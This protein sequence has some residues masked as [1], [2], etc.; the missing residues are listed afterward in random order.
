MI[1]LRGKVIALMP[2]MLLVLLCC[3]CR[4][5]MIALYGV[6]RPHYLSDREI[7]REGKK[8]GYENICKTDT[9]AYRNYVKSLEPAQDTSSQFGVAARSAKACASGVSGDL[10]Q[11]LQ[12]MCFDQRGILVSYYVNCYAGGF[13]NLKWNR[14]N[15]FA[16]FP[17]K[18]LAPIYKEIKLADV[19]HVI[20]SIDNAQ[21]VQNPDYTVIIF[22][23]DFMGRQSNRL[24]KYL[25]KSLE[26]V[27]EKTSVKVYYVNNDNV[28]LGEDLF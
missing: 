18:T 17:P 15:G 27:D 19:K 16:L 10:L 11:P 21:P 22:W 1:I 12:L 14:D 8:R 20:A 25:R 3:G 9:A 5:T 24:A 6:K 13:P 2:I 26:N 28:F 4:P 23:N 7:V